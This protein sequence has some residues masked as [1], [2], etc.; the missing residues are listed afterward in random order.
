[1][2]RTE[3]HRAIQRLPFAQSRVK[4]GIGSSGAGGRPFPFAA[5]VQARYLKRDIA[6]GR[7]V[8]VAG[9]VEGF[10][11][12]RRGG[13]SSGF[14]YSR[15]R[16]GGVSGGLLGEVHMEPDGVRRGALPFRVRRNT[17]RTGYFQI[18]LKFP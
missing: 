3:R 9:A 8:E 17:V 2:R 4:A 5:A 14:S 1:M 10:A 12:D 15:G 16:E 13:G 18:K 7:K 11:A 6:G